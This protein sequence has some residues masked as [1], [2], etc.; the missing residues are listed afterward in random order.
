MLSRIQKTQKRTSIYFEMIRNITTELF[1]FYALQS[2]HKLFDKKNHFFLYL[3]R[4]QIM[5]YNSLKINKKITIARLYKGYI[6]NGSKKKS[7]N[8]SL[9]FW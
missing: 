9:N 4:F 5:K 7:K 2:H 3:K 8:Y 6:K 1:I